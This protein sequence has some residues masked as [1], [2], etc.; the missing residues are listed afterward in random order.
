M[1]IFLASTTYTTCKLHLNFFSLQNETIF[2]S[3]MKSDS[4][5]WQSLINNRLLTYGRF[6]KDKVMAVDLEGGQSG[7]AL[8]KLPVNGLGRSE[9]VRWKYRD[10]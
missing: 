6:R 4:C 8:R 2:T 7:A 3:V 10:R 1:K 5:R 9:K